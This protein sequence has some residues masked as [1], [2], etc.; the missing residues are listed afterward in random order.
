ML[1]DS[2]RGKF[3]IRVISGFQGGF[4]QKFIR[5]RLL[6]YWSFGRFSTYCKISIRFSR[7][8]SN[9][10]DYLVEPKCPHCI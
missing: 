8:R 9:F 5:H 6:K 4:V 2:S 7:L 10:S 3:P 1:N